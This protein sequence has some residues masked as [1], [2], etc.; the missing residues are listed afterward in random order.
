MKGMKTNSKSWSQLLIL[1]VCAAIVLAGCQSENISKTYSNEE[2]AR[3]AGQTNTQMLIAAQEAL[4]ITAG[5]M[6]EKGV[7]GGR[8]SG[9]DWQ[10][11]FAGCKPS[12]NLTLNIDRSRTDSLVYSG[13]ISINY[14]DGASCGAE[15]RKTGLIVDDFVLSV[16]KKNKL[17]F[18][19]T[20]TITFTGFG[21]EVAE[22]DGSLTVKSANGRKTSVE[23]RNAKIS[24]DDGTNSSWNGKLEFAYEPTTQTAVQRK[25]DIR[26]TGNLTGFTRQGS[27]YTASI[28]ESILFKAGCF[29]KKRPFPVS[30]VLQVKTDAETSTVNYG[31]GACDK[32]Y[33][34]EVAG[35]TSQH[36]IM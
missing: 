26:M 13:S 16:S 15:F 2:K 11:D 29:G 1:T 20:E 7:S 34:V 19:A 22:V 21:N 12:V 9:S 30:G 8:V 14:G 36:T 27:N 24:F 23:A 3:L 33:T 10:D 6:N 25:S 4:D 35:Q 5:A 17:A 18:K 28:V 32:N 31:T